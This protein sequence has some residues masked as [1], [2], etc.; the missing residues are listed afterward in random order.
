MKPVKKKKNNDKIIKIKQKA[1][2][3][4]TKATY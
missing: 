4:L 2:L 3:N 1:T